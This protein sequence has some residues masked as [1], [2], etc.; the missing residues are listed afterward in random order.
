MHFPH[1]THA[2]TAITAKQAPP[3]T[4]PTIAPTGILLPVAELGP[5]PFDGAVVTEVNTVV[6]TTSMRAC[7]CVDNGLESA[8]S[9]DRVLG[10]NMASMSNNRFPGTIAR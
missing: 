4:P 10:G 6:V 3:A 9:G 2:V 8:S 7:M 5:K 1:H